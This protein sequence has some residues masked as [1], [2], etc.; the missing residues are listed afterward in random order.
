MYLAGSYCYR[1]NAM[2]P[3]GLAE[4]VFATYLYLAERIGLS[5]VK[6]EPKLPHLETLF[7]GISVNCHFVGHRVCDNFFKIL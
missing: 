3:R 4:L 1:I 6:R 7:Q 2:T 5:Y